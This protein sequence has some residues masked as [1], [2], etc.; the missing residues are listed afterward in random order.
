MSHIRALCVKS[1]RQ[2]ANA[3][4]ILRQQSVF[5]MVVILFFAAGL[6][7]ALYLLF[8]NGFRFLDNFGG[9]GSLIVRRLFSVF[10]L[11]MSGML[12]MSGLATS[13]MTLY[14]SE[15]VPFLL[16]GPIPVADV[17]VYKFLQSTVL[18]SWAFFFIILPFMAA[19][20]VH[21]R[22]SPLFAFWT[23]AFSA[24]FLLVC[25]GA[26]TIV[27]MLLVRWRP[28]GRALKGLIVAGGVAAV[29]AGLAALR[30]TYGSMDAAT[31]D[32]SRMVPG[33]R[34][35]ANPLL[36]GWWMAE[37][38]MAL[39]AGRWGRGLM[40]W[41][42]LSASAA[43]VVVAV[44]GL[45]ARTYLAALRRVWAGGGRGG[46]AAV[47]LPVLDRLLLRLSPD[48][49]AMAAKDARVFLRDPSQ[50]SQT[51]VFFGL[52]AI[53][54]AN[55]R[56]FRYHA[57][58]D[59]WRHLIAFLNVFSVSAVMC[60]LGSRFV[61][62]QLSLEGQGFWILGLSPTTMRRIL[63]TKFTLA[64]AALLTVGVP[65]MLLSTA[66]L[67]ATVAIRAVSLLLIVS[68]SV[69]TAGLSSGL[70]A[71][72]LDL[73]QSNPAAIVSGF[74]GTLNLVLSLAYMLSGILPFGLLFH[75]DAIGALTPSMLRL[76]LAASTVW[77][78]ALTVAATTVPLWIGARALD[79]R[80]Y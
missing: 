19:Y 14:R 44:E 45:A 51:L 27:T 36:P 31:F 33:F 29:A 37:G 23:L 77:L 30:T 10:F 13:Y 32:L 24:P 72:F 7:A 2:A 76:A 22:L 11:G 64:A 16:T 49:R 47:L 5:K 40:L 28:G 61:Y 35:A 26:G 25:S 54:F 57:L 68:Q 17:A 9:I 20:A 6:E 70:G 12:A 39:S 66:M 52:L 1:A 60:S 4:R 59:V 79:R 15:E 71:I 38:I 34:A 41:L 43:A 48:A 78:L 67:K 50:W 80:D 18:S 21:Q 53:Y 46:R 75:L 65:L 73:R 69:A 74:G 63:L 62:P 42:T 58:P 3:G 56:S 55:L 8:R